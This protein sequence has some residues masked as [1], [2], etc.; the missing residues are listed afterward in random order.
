MKFSLEYNR[1]RQTWF[2][3]RQGYLFVIARSFLDSCS[4]EEREY[5]IVSRLGR[6]PNGFLIEPVDKDKHVLVMHSGFECSSWNNRTTAD[7]LPDQHPGLDLPKF[8]TPGRVVEAV[9]ITSNVCAGL[10]APIQTH[11]HLQSIL[12]SDRF[13][14]SNFT[15]ND[16]WEKGKPL[17]WYVQGF[18]K[19][20][21]GA[22]YI[23]LGDNRAC[24]LPSPEET[25]L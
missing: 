12:R 3:R 23:E 25:L 7:V 9:R 10:K 22:C 15:R 20:K 1:V 4:T 16:R 8:V 5:M 19:P 6:H 18:L 2:T 13:D 11:A 24:G 21:P 14:P 17:A